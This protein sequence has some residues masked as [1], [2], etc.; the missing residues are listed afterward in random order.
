MLKLSLYQAALGVLCLSVFGTAAANASLS[1]RVIDSPYNAI[2]DGTTDNYTALAKAFADI[3]AAGGGTLH[4]PAGTFLIKCTNGTVGYAQPLRVGTNTAIEGDDREKSRISVGTDSTNPQT[5]NFREFI[6][7]G[8]GLSHGDNVTIRKPT[9]Y[10]SAASY[11]ELLL[12]SAADFT[13]ENS[14][15][16]GN[17]GTY[18]FPKDLFAGIWIASYGD[19][20]NLKI[21]NVEFTQMDLAL[22]E[23]SSSTG[24]V[25]GIHVTNSKFVDMNTSGD[26]LT[27]NS[28]S[29]VTKN[30]SV[31]RSLFSGFLTQ[32]AGSG[33][34]VSFANVQYASV[35]NSIFL[36][37][38]NDCF[39][40]EN[41]SANIEVKHNTFVG[42]GK[43]FYGP[44]FVV[45]SS[46]GI[47]G[48]TTHDITFDANVIDAR[49]N[50]VRP[51]SPY[52]LLVTSGGATANQPVDIN[53][54]SNIF[55]N[56]PYSQA[57]YMQPGSEGT[58]EN[59]IVYSLAQ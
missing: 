58:I 43:L 56:G 26:G 15:I 46:S 19:V 41:R 24:T 7:L 9:I 6:R 35:T 49:S 55:W 31:D 4:V 59:N 18:N 48:A 37:T 47:P 34:V 23:L 25:D 50:T 57:W 45:G 3:D 1:V 44:L 36:N 40:V 51:L 54:T 13:L 29:G 12:V 33:G 28:P 16:N 11:L 8:T 32:N 14:T 27:F 21:D 2:G 53:V 17:N 38:N 42:C 20:T 52:L 30:V 22:W 39:H 10:K 5:D